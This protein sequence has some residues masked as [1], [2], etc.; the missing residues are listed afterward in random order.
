MW[1]MALALSARG[2]TRA[3][4][5]D[6]AGWAWR[7][8]EVM[9][10][11][12]RDLK[13]AEGPYYYEEIFLRDAKPGFAP[14]AAF[15]WSTGIHLSAIN[16]G[17]RLEP[18]RYVPMIAPYL[19]MKETYWVEKDG[20]GG[21]CDSPHPRRPE[22]YYDDNAWIV[23][24]LI[25]SYEITKDAA[26]LR[27]AREAA[28]FV[29]SGEDDVL[30]GGLYWFEAKKES[31]NTCANAPG[32]VCAARLYKITGEKAYLETATRLYKWTREKLQDQDGLYFDNLRLNGRIGR[33]KFTYN[34][35]LMIRAGCE[36]YDATRDD[37]YLKE[38][39][40]VAVA[41]V[42]HWVKGQGE[43]DDNSYFAHLLAEAW[44]EVGA[45]DKDP[46]WGRAVERA[47]TFVWEKGR[48]SEDRFPERWNRAVEG[49]T[50]GGVGHVT[51]K[52]QASAARAFFRLAWFEKTGT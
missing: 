18:G 3:A 45:R 15:A 49:T 4:P 5:E 33:A 8:D 50:G 26:I 37:A 20:L 23:L 9:K 12:E 29:F 2:Q 25:E 1:V 13:P 14:K 31:K 11:I 36:L 35:A 42:A 40:R 46:R 43:I 47:E 38:A 34:S 44:L 39:Q 10:A 16:A 7:G 51:L 28:K 19:K 30:G 41:A 17:A 32:I 52:N 6:A 24:D 48:D 22:R 27:R 21:Y